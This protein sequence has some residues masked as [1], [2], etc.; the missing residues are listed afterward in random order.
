VSIDA[1]WRRAAHRRAARSTRPRTDRASQHGV[2]RSASAGDLCAR[3]RSRHVIRRAPEADAQRVR[4]A[5]GRSPTTGSSCG[6]GWRSWTRPGR[7]R[8]G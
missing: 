5:L 6:C 2:E 8:G 4:L 7:D 3:D 1:A